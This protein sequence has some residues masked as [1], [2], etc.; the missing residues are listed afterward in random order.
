MVLQTRKVHRAFEKAATAACSSI[1]SRALALSLS[2][3]EREL[4]RVSLV[5]FTVFSPNILI[6]ADCDHLLYLTLRVISLILHYH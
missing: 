2:D 6:T 3:G 1:K 4:T 5:V